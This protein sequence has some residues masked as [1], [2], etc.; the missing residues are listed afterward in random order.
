[1]IKETAKLFSIKDDVSTLS[2]FLKSQSPKVAIKYRRLMSKLCES[3]VDLKVEM[4]SPNRFYF[5]TNFTVDEISRSL[6]ALNNEINNL[7]YNE[8]LIGEIV[9]INV[10]KRTFS[11]NVNGDYIGGKISDSFEDTIFEVSK[12]V[13]VEIKQQIEINSV[14]NDEKYIYTLLKII[15][16]FE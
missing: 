2:E 10:A 16:K 9:G 12:F 7:S 11:F 14:T 1:M 15:D 5:K 3:N 4:A 6:N 13:K 8:E